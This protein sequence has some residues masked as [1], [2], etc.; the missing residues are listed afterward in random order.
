MSKAKRLTKQ[1]HARHAA[2]TPSGE[3]TC[4]A[5]RRTHTFR[6]GEDTGTTPSSL[7][8]TFLP[9][10]LGPC[11]RRILTCRQR[12]RRAAREAEC[13]ER[14]AGGRVAICDDLFTTGITAQTTAEALQ[15]CGAEVVG[16]YTLA[17][18]ERTEK[19]PPEERRR[20]R[21]PL[22]CPISGRTR[23]MASV[24]VC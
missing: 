22:L 1:L 24:S 7:H 16:V 23:I 8:T 5:L 10:G 18:T 13:L 20:L 17:M 19:R 4:R 3:A 2:H 12:R 11:Y 21:H 6:R 9:A 15:E 14:L